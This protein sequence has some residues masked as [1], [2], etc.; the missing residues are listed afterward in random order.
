GRSP[1][2][3]VALPLVVNAGA[4]ALRDLTDPVAI[5]A[6]SGLVTSWLLGWRPWQLAGWAV[7]AVL[8]REQDLVLILIVLLQA[9]SNRRRAVL[10]AL[11]VALLT[12]FGWIC[13]LRGC[14]GVWPFV[15]DNL[16]MPF[17]GIYYRLTHMLGG[18]GTSCSPVHVVGMLLLS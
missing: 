18:R 16:N 10:G 1:W 5:L 7:A 6:T 13:I 2:W 11:A 4:P 8:S 15:S 3:G 12:W 9:L 17:E 14:Y